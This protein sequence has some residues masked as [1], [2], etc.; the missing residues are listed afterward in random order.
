VVCWKWTPAPGYRSQFTPDTV[1]ILRAMVERHLPLPHEFVCVTDQPEGIDPRVRIV[2]L[3]ND[4]RT[5]PSPWGGKNPSCYVRLKAFAPDAKEIL[6]ARILSLDLDTVITDDLTPLVDRPEEFIIYGDT[7][8]GTPY[9]GGCWLLT[10][11]A[12]PQVW[13]QFD[14]RRSPALGK[15]RG[16]VGSDQAWLGVILGPHEKKW[17]PADG[18]YSYRVDLAPKGGRLPRN[19][20]MVH[21]HGEQK[22]WSPQV[23]ARH[24]WIQKH[25]R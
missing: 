14:P 12:R 4:H 17:G 21:F 7:A 23:K 25:Y 8:K 1:N 11:G 15:A 22:P 20:R 9:N 2:P 24:D 13:T 19:A 5:V 3:W 6:G 10:A 18:M 16:Y